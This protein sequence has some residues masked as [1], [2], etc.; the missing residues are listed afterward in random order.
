[1]INGD[2]PMSE[3]E[4]VLEHARVVLA[5]P[6]TVHS[7]MMRQSVSPLVQRFLAEL[8]LLVIDEA[9]V[10]EGVFGTNAAFLFRRT[11][12]CSPPGSSRDELERAS[13]DRGDGDRHRTRGS[14]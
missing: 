7:W 13:G 6:D 14:P 8:K 9:H 5:T 4:R 12:R 10:L 3:R 1:M 11:F 2:I